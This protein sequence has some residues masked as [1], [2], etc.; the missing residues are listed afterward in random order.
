MPERS[1]GPDSVWGSNV[2][3]KDRCATVV[4]KHHRVTNNSSKTSNV[5]T[6]VTDSLVQGLGHDYIDPAL[7]LLLA[8]RS[9]FGW[10]PFL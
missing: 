10:M 7:G 3:Y 1:Y 6:Y 4:P 9:N 2:T 8:H 5:Q